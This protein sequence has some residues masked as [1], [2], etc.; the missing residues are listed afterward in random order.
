VRHH[1]AGRRRPDRPVLRSALPVFVACALTA[2]ATAGALP[3]VAQEAD[4]SQQRAEV[5]QRQ[6]E[7]ASQID[8]LRAS[9]ADVKQALETISENVSA[10]QNRVADIRHALADAS[11][12]YDAAQKRVQQAQ[13]QL[14]SLNGKLRDLAVSSYIR[15][16]DDEAAGVMVE[17]SPLDAPKRQALARFRVRSLDDVV[18]QVRGQREDL[19]RAQQQAAAARDEADRARAAEEQRLSGLEA[20]QAQ[21]ETF[22]ADVDD[23]L[24]RALAESASLSQQD[25]ALAAEIQRRQDELA[26]QLAAARRSSGSST[27][28]GSSASSSGS[29][30]SSG[31]VSVTTVGGIEVNVAIA[32]QLAAMLNAAAAD[33]VSLSGSGYRDSSE[34]VALRAQN[35]GGSDYAIYEMSSSECSPPTARPGRS[36]HEQGLAIDFSA[37][38]SLIQ[39]RGSSGYQWLAAHGADYGFYNLPSEPWHWSTTGS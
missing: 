22:A 36:M 19:T 31:S 37:N 35:C 14:D 11:A 8:T 30:R 25:Q 18:D 1:A 17:G 39:S 12:A 16:P 26:A 29:V 9:D 33:G 7:V 21:Q 23:R 27:G 13:D 24:D 3:A 38:G 5:Q 20:A 4:P 28:S 32:S 10:Q 6:A 2:L 34:Q 15:P